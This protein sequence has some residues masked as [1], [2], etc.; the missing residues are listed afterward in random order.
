MALTVEDGSIVAGAN[1][2]ASVSDV[3]AYATSRGLTW[4]GGEAEVLQA[5]QYIESLPFA[6]IPRNRTQSLRFPRAGIVYDGYELPWDEIPQL[7]KDAVC[8]GAIEQQSADLAPNL[9]RGGQIKREK[10]D[11][12]EM[13]YMDGAPSGKTFARLNLLLAPLIK[14]GTR[15]VLS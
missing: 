11:V 1:S 3:D 6:G 4:S 9:D 2:Y 14:S 13:E 5:M 8:Q 7:L 15:L 10:I 12:I